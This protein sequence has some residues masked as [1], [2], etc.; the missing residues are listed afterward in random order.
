M[1]VVENSV[2]KTL[3][4]A[5]LYLIKIIPMLFAFLSL[6]NDALSYFNEVN[7]N[8]YATLSKL[9]KGLHFCF[10]IT[11]FAQKLIL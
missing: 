5:E 6:L 11:N 4:K 7:S 1:A 3:Y 8:Y 9:L 2:N 10:K